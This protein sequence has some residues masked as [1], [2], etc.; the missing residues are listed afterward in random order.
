[1]KEEILAI[2]VKHGK[3]MALELV[4][5]VAIQALEE[6]VKKSET[7]IDDVIVAALKEPLK[8]AL[9]KLIQEA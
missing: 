6:A 1:M 8:Q 4:E 5:Q 7:P 2:V 3:A 9:I